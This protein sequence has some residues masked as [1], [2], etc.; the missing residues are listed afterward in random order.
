MFENGIQDSADVCGYQ[1]NNAGRIE[2]YCIEPS[3]NGAENTSYNIKCDADVTQTSSV[4]DSQTDSVSGL[5]NNT[6]CTIEA[7]SE[8]EQL[9]DSY[10]YVTDPP[11]QLEAR[12]DDAVYQLDTSQYRLESSGGITCSIDQTSSEVNAD[13]ATG[14]LVLQCVEYVDGGGNVTKCDGNGQMT[15]AFQSTAVTATMPEDSY[16][17]VVLP[18]GSRALRKIKP[19]SSTSGGLNVKEV[20]VVE[21]THTPVMTSSA[22][23]EAGQGISG[24]ATVVV[25]AE[26]PTRGGGS[27]YIIL[28][29]SLVSKPGLDGSSATVVYQLA[30]GSSIIQ[31]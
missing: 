2:V 13:P 14:G 6:Y 5:V 18:N 17:I 7:Q 19:A 30:D 31:G 26:T 10:R 22:V 25:D 12:S 24:P 28:P 1:L 20:Q 15:H 8:T 3:S 23:A 21:A 16:E 27:S 11:Y 9:Q 4:D 29:S